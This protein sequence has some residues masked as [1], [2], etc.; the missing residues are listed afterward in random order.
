MDRR[1]Y[2]TAAIAMIRL[3]A[4][5][6][7]ASVDADDMPIPQLDHLYHVAKAHQMAALTAIA[8]QRRGIK[9]AQFSDALAKAQ[10]KSLLF[11][12][13]LK[14][15]TDSLEKN[16]ITF[17]PLKGMK[18]KVLY[19][20]IGS[21]EMSDIDILI[22]QNQAARA[23]EIMIDAGYQV[24]SYQKANHD[25]YIKQPFFCFELHRELF[26]WDHHSS[27]R[28]YFE[29]LAYAP[30]GD[31]P[32][33]LE[34]TVSEMY[35]YLMAHHHAHYYSAG[36]GLRSLTDL[37]LYLRRYENEL[38]EAYIRSAFE[39]IGIGDFAEKTRSLAKRFL[40]ID[41]L[42]DEQSAE[43]DYYIF[44]GT[45]GTKKQHLSNKV[46][47]ETDGSVQSKLRY[48][49]KRLE[50]NDYRVKKSPFYSKHPKLVPLMKITQPI[51]SFVKKPRV[52]LCELKAL[53]KRKKK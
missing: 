24:K 36:V 16:K 49:K 20:A 21:R 26:N 17:L 10:R 4:E 50:V 32:Y 34:M 11:D 38:D 31:S 41:K 6:L 27:Y 14:I 33:R 30:A 45:F 1:K 37:Y 40:R 7:G 23:K 39:Q 47:K 48:L 25:V 5:A 2:K 8:L 22:D 43:L 12:R 28:A 19:P 53:K 13:E 52:I 15:I 18:L 35:V 44:S 29:S 3:I 51:T 9:D 46:L 42:D